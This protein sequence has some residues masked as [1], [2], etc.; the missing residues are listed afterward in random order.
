MIRRPPISTRTATPVP[1]TT[2]FRSMAASSPAQV[3]ELREK[4][5]AGMM[6]CKQALSQTEGDMEAAVDWLRKKGLAAA[7]KKAGRVAA[8]GL[9][10]VSAKGGVGAVVEVNAERSEE[11][12]SELQSLM[13]ISYAVFCLKKKQTNDGKRKEM[14]YTYYEITRRT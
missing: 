14:C 7:A 10:G 8:E 6:D 3:K 2:L 11:H 9:V 4:T 1:Y 12:T 5:G 13:R